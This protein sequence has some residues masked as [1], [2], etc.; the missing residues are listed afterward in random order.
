M[1]RRAGQY[2]RADNHK[3]PT[4]S[5]AHCHAKA[6]LRLWTLKFAL[7]KAPPGGGHLILAIAS[8]PVVLSAAWGVGRRRRGLCTILRI[9]MRISMR[10]SIG[11]L[12]LAL[13]AGGTDAWWSGGGGGGR[14]EGEGER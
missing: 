12:E 7:T 5:H 14:G 13:G 1:Q 2:E 11:A 6:G 4:R 8:A 10:I 9:S 3:W